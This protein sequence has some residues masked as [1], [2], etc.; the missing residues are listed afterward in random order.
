[1]L[2]IFLEVKGALLSLT[3]ILMMENINLKNYEKE[4][5]MCYHKHTIVE[6]LIAWIDSK[7]DPALA[8]RICVFILSDNKLRRKSKW[9]KLSRYFFSSPYF[10]DKLLVLTDYQERVTIKYK[11]RKKFLDYLLLMWEDNLFEPIPLQTFVRYI[12]YCFITHYKP[13]SIRT[14]INHRKL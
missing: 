2:P 5:Y 4:I 3:S 9:K 6:N 14:K 10:M 11:E 13:G 1:M 8:F 12:T 7:E